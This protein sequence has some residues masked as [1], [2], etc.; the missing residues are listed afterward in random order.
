MPHYYNGTIRD[1]GTP[2]PVYQSPYGDSTWYN[3]KKG[4][5]V[6]NH[7]SPPE[8]YSFTQC[9]SSF[10]L[11][12][13][14]TETRTQTLG[15]SPVPPIPSVSPEVPIIG[16]CGGHCPGFE[17]VCYYILQVCILKPNKSFSVALSDLFS[18]F[19]FGL[20]WC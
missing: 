10:S 9:P 12:L 2:S 13:C 18:W 7:S 16:A 1:Y 8:P 20:I 19:R 4:E 17:Y 6:P 14:E 15:R 11:P 5:R 3:Y